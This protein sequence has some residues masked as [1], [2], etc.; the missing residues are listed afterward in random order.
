ME[1]LW[2]GFPTFTTREPGHEAQSHPP[3]R[4]PRPGSVA[5][6][7]RHS[8]DQGPHPSPRPRSA[9]DEY[10]AHRVGA[11]RPPTTRTQSASGGAR[12]ILNL[13]MPRG[14][15]PHTDAPTAPPSIHPP[16]TPPTT[17]V[18]PPP[19]PMPRPR[20]QASISPAPDPPRPFLRSPRVEPIYAGRELT[21][22]DLAP[23][24]DP[25]RFPLLAVISPVLLA[26]SLFTAPQQP[27]T[28]LFVALSP[29][30]M[31][32]T[33]VDARTQ[34]RRVAKAATAQFTTD[35]DALRDELDTERAVEQAA[36]CAEYP[37]LT[38]I[39]T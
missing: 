22:P 31:L 29:L 2:I 30:I 16:P 23:P 13:G 9:H 27:T 20:H 32:V 21:A 15:H 28:L 18:P 19:T 26:A 4:R 37:D 5:D 35:R 38:A 34:Q 14:P 1:E 7:G 8:D 6:P 25:P 17:P 33:W 36:R 3:Q 39:T 12:D 10:H 24:R 11:R